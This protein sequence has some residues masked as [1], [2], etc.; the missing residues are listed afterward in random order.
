MHAE[1]YGSRTAT[2]ALRR[3][4]G[5]PVVA[6]GT[7]AL[8]TLE[9]AAPRR[10]AAGAGTT[11][12]FIYP[13]PATL[14][15][16]RS[17]DHELPPAASTLLMLVCAFAGTERVLAAYREAVARGYRFFSYGD[18]MLL[19]RRPTM[20]FTLPTP[21]FS[22]ELLATHGT[23]APGI[24]H[25]PRGEIPTPCSCRSAPPGTVKAMTA[26]EL[27]APP[28]D[29]QIILGNTYHLYL[30]PGLEVIGRAV[31]CTVRGAGTGRSSPTPAASRSSR[32]PRS[33]RSTTTASRSARTSTARTHRLTPEVSMEIQARARLGHRDGFDQ[34]PPGD[35]DAATPGAAL[36]RTT[37]VGRA[38]PGR[39]ARAGAGAVRDRPGRHRRRAPAAPPRRAHRA[40]LRRLRARR[41]LGRRAASP[42][43]TGCSTRSPMCCPPDGRA[44]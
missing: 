12:L 30:R 38:L 13:G 28:L 18:A 3:R 37:R 20:I 42:T 39:A 6:L 44:T 11:D 33:T 36:A 23:R 2:A 25:T 10:G 4:A 19:H 40:R 41:A 34:C 31:G 9:A 14:P 5:A 27:R 22:F 26:D 32:S 15:R 35:A 21:G 7:T 17:P 8:R 1:R 16:R 29:A 43:C 24:L